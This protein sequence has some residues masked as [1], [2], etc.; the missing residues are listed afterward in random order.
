MGFSTEPRAEYLSDLRVSRRGW[1]LSAPLD[2]YP[3]YHPRPPSLGDDARLRG[4]YIITE[5]D[6]IDPAVS[7]ISISPSI[8]EGRY[9]SPEALEEENDSGHTPAGDESDTMLNTPP[10]NG[11]SPIGAER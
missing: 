9:T 1:R 4:A 6:R 11:I 10:V 2:N 3:R 7:A 8:D 5:H